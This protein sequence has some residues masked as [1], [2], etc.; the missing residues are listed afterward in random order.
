MAGLSA[1]G[2]PTVR[3]N[4]GQFVVQRLKNTLSLPKLNLAYADDPATWP[5]RSA[6]GDRDKCASRLLWQSHARS[7]LLA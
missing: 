7:S 2:P 6:R 3:Q 1:L 5:G 4:H